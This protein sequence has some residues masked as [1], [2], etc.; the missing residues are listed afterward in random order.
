M[1]ADGVRRPASGEEELAVGS[2]LGELALEP[3]DE[4]LDAP[5][6]DEEVRAE[7]DRR[8]R[9]AALARPGERLLELGEAFPAARR[10]ARARPCRSS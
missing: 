2:G 1:E 9:Q 6:G 5:V 4:R 8:D 7:P 3:Q 10:R